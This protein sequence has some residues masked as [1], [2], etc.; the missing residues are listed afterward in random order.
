M[1]A[2]EKLR[3]LWKKLSF[4]SRVPYAWSKSKLKSSQEISHLDVQTYYLLHE[5]RDIGKMG[6]RHR[7]VILGFSLDCRLHKYTRKVLAWVQHTK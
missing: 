1:P 2:T 7:R 6:D 3:H 4:S 5:C